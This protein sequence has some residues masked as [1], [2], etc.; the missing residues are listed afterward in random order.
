MTQNNITENPSI[1]AVPSAAKHA[2]GAAA[3][4][5]PAA[6]D[7]SAASAGA[8]EARVQAPARAS[9]G[10]IASRRVLPDVVEA[11]ISRGVRI[12]LTK[13]GYEIEGFYRWG[14]MRLEP[15]AKFGGLMAIDRKEV[16]VPI[17]TFDE[18]VRLNY[19]CWKKSRDKGAAFINPGK[20]WIDE[21][22]RLNLVKRQVIFVPGDE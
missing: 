5:A 17:G 14:P 6:A 15:D 12:V 19:D 13:A 21:F 22:A 20:E 8:A 4:P 16:V 2:A 1:P 7:A 11:A 3:S 9:S 10:F 18:L